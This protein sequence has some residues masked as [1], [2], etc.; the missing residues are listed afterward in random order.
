M[1]VAAVAAVAPLLAAAIP[2]IS[3][4]A[5]VIEFALG[6]IVGPDVLGW[7]KIDEPLA[8]LSL[9]ALGFLLFLPGAEGEVELVRETPLT[10]AIVG[11]VVGLAIAFAVAFVLGAAD[12]VLTP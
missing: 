2:K 10:K 12:V 6:V 11:Y 8:V 4:P 7:V 3:V 9:L 1:I 5:I